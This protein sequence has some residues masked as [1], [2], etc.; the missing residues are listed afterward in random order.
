MGLPENNKCTIQ[1]GQEIKTHFPQSF[2]NNEMP[3]KIGSTAE[4][5]KTQIK[6]Y[7]NQAKGLTFDSNPDPD[8]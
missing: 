5:L 1:F 2:F 4:N 8:S 3:F 7:A 6:K